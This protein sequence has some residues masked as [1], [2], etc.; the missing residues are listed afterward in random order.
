MVN[1]LILLLVFMIIAAVIALWTEDLLSSVI[2][3]GAVGFGSSVA[4][5]LLSAPD[6]AITQIVVEVLTLVLL[7]RATVGRDVKTTSGSRDVFGLAVSGAL[8]LILLVFA[9][10]TAQ[11]LPEFGQRPPVAREAAPAAQYLTDGLD[12]TGSANIVT[13]V[14]LDYRAYDTLGEATVLFAAVVGAM[15]LLRRRSRKEETPAE[16]EQT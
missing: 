6:L 2:A 14:L 8:V 16:E 12:K 1:L 13:A 4:F 7:I 3:V 15:T 9:V 5:L 11:S 10:Q